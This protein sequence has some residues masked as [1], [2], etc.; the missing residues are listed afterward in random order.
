MDLG[1]LQREVAVIIDVTEPSIRNWEHGTEPELQ[2]K[3]FLDE[4]GVVKRSPPCSSI[5]I[6]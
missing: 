3:L 5:E 4:Q 2:I 6:L 1:P